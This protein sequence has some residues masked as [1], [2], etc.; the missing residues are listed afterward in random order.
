VKIFQ[1]HN[2]YQY[3]GGE[4]AVA[5]AEKQLLEDNGHAVI[6]YLRHNDEI[7]DFSLANKVGLFL[8]ATWSWKTFRQLKSIL[9]KEQPDLAHFHNTLPLISPGAYYACIKVNVPVVQTLHNYR[10][11]CPSALLFRDGNICEECLTHSL[12]RSIQ[13]GCYRGSRIQTMAVA[14]MLAAHRSLETWRRKIDAYVVLTNFSRNKFIRYGLPAEKIFTKP[15]FPKRPLE[16]SIANKRSVLSLGRLSAEKGLW[17]L[18]KAWENLK[19]IRLKIAGDGPL[20]DKLKITVRE[21][22]L[23]NV[24]FLGYQSHSECRELLKNAGFVIL[25]SECYEGFP[26]IAAEAFAAGKLLIATNLG[27]MA[28]MIDD[29]QTGLHFSPGDYQE[30]AAKVEWAWSHPRAV[31]RMGLAARKEYENKYTAEK[32]YAILMDIYRR[33]I[34]QKGD[35]LSRKW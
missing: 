18:L 29:G 21:N 34:A 32:N 19:H 31:K 3:Y 5:D 26:M 10:L 25:P 15:N 13:H 12:V 1:I 24:E 7:N 8:N 6:R 14:L 30:L 33:V 16:Y 9:Q 27:A 4:D 2:R 28:E 35:E 22:A 17:T 23:D 20:S 11:I